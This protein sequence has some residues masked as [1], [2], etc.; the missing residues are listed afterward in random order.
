MV[1]DTGSYLAIF[2][3]LGI[4]TAAT[5]AG[6]GRK[7]KLKRERRER[8]LAAYP[9]THDVVASMDTEKYTRIRDTRGRA[10]IVHAVRA[11]MRD[12]PGLTLE[13]AADVAKSLDPR[14]HDV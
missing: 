7:S 10:G 13:E 8:H 11:L 5:L 3:A 9:S 14:K 2:G 6:S 12:F 4:A 1:M